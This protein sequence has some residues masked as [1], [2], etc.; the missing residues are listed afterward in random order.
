MMPAR[1]ELACL[2]AEDL[3]IS[4]GKNQKM[5]IKRSIRNYVLFFFR[6]YRQITWIDKI[7]RIIDKQRVKNI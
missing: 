2:V 3:G 4:S 5:E 6:Y 7:D 1:L